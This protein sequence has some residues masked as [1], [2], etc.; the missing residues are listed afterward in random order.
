FY[1]NCKSIISFLKAIPSVLT[2]WGSIRLCFDVD[3]NPD[4]FAYPVLIVTGRQD[5]VVGFQD[6]WRFVDKYPR[7]TFAVLDMAGHNLQIERSNLFEALVHDW[8]D[9]LENPGTQ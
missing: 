4:P 6:A 1:L 3:S 2:M 8:L 9:R 7:A 5:D